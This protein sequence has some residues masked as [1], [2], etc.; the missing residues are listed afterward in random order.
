M[1]PISDQ[2]DPITVSIVDRLK[3]MQPHKVVLFGSHARGNAQEDSD[4]DLLVVT[5]DDWLPAN[6]KEKSDLY[7]KV[8]H[9]LNGISNKTPIDLI[10]LTKSMYNKFNHLGSVFSKEIRENGV[11]LYEAGH[12]GMAQ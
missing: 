1:V 7:L 6:Y 8:S 9:L 5:N 4:I 3:T 10:V 12:Q 2:T 11:I